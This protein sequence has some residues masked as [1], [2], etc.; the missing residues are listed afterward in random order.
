VKYDYLIKPIYENYIPDFS[1]LEIELKNGLDINY[2]EGELGDVYS[3]GETM[4]SEILFYYNENFL[5][6][7]ETSYL[8]S[9]ENPNIIVVVNWFIEHGYDVNRYDGYNGY[10]ALA[11]LANSLLC[12]KYSVEAFKILLDHYEKTDHIYLKWELNDFYM[13]HTIGSCD[14]IATNYY[15]TLISI[16]EYYDVGKDFKSIMH[17][18]FAVGK[19]ISKIFVEESEDASLN[20]ENKTFER[21]IFDMED[22][23]LVVSRDMHLNMNCKDDYDKERIIECSKLENSIGSRI[24]NIRYYYPENEE[25]PE[26]SLNIDLDSGKRVTLKGRFNGQIVQNPNYYNEI[27]GVIL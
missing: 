3:D 27:W 19:K 4:L 1:L 6:K 5:P 24:K 22:S 8:Y 15:S 21:L 17:P 13:E 12:D 7:D 2:L 25:K 23:F 18:D 16:I 14:R 9:F 20:G 10:Y 11:S 26:I